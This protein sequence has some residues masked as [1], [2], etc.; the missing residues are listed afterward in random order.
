MSCDRDCTLCIW[1]DWSPFDMARDC[2]L[3][4][5]VRKV[6]IPI[7]GQGNCPKEK[8]FEYYLQESCNTQA[9]SGTRSASPGM[10]SYWT[11][12]VAAR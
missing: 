10:I 6:I 5:R 1:T 9:A 12:T 11:S 8:S 4:E 3:H 7:R 2:G